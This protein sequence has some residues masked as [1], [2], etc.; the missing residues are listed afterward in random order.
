MLYRKIIAVCSEIHTKHTNTLCGQNEVFLH[1]K[2]TVHIFCT[3]SWPASSSVNTERSFCGVTVTG[4]YD[5]TASYSCLG[6]RIPP[7]L[8]RTSPLS[9]TRLANLQVFLY[10]ISHSDGAETFRRTCIAAST[11]TWLSR[12]QSLLKLSAYLNCSSYGL[13]VRDQWTPSRT[14]KSTVTA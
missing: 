2:L 5:Q 12:V 1:I 7:P 4:A 13:D 10:I 8:L 6:L 3:T 14:S 9:V 11:I